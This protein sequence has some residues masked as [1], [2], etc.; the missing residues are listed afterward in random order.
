MK[1]YLDFD[2]TLFDTDRFLEDLNA[3]SNKYHI[4]D[5]LFDKHYQL[6][7]EEGFNYRNT[8]K[9]IEKEFSFDKEIYHEY[10]DFL[11]KA[12]EY[13]YSDVIP[14]LER[15]KNNYKIILFTKGNEDF[16]LEKINNTNLINYFD[17]IMISLKDK[18]ELDI[19]YEECIFI[20]D[21][22]HE[23]DSIN[24]RNPK[25]IIRISR[26]N[27]RYQSMEAKTK[28]EI[29]SSLEEIKL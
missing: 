16:Q 6:L 19:P 10:D 9:S 2:R 5:E 17:A 15:V 13:V 18:G 4:T 12:Q 21:N 23:L 1:I 8:L 11:K 7:K 3:I 14:F 25:R 24:K 26:E 29:V 28:T 20:D 27:T 22:P